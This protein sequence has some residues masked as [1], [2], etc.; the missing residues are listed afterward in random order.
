MQLRTDAIAGALVSPFANQNNKK[1]SIG[2]NVR[3][4]RLNGKKQQANASRNV[5]VPRTLRN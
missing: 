5:I 3:H 1:N 2:S 4:I